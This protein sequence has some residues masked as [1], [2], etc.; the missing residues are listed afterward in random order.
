MIKRNDRIGKKYGRLTVIA[1]TGVSR[2]GESQYLFQCD[3]GNQLIASGGNIF[4]GKQKSCGCLQKE[5]GVKRGKTSAK[6]GLYKTR[7]YRIWCGMKRRCYTPSV[8]NFNNYGGRGIKVCNEWQEF[9][10][11]YEWA[12][13]NG[14]KEDLTLDRIDVNGNYEPSNCRWTTWSEQAKNKRK[15]KG[16]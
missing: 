2:W 6:H 12:M 14:Y 10:P 11:F 4:R 15:A 7:P 5:N 9:I 16:E 13:S 3:C 1:C 8:H